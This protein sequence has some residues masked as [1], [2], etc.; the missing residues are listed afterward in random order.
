MPGVQPS[1]DSTRQF[2]PST[3]PPTTA[4]MS[5]TDSAL[6]SPPA[7]DDEMPVEMPVAKPAKPQPQSKA[8]KAKKNGTILSFLEKRA[9]SP[10]RKKREPSPPHEP[11][12]EDNFDIAVS[13][14][15]VRRVMPRCDRVL[16]FIH[17]RNCSPLTYLP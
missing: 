6:S 11:A 17:A 4:N 16:W 15:R 14:C 9:P 10:P 2:L 7:T 1:I 12:F 5:D 13:L 3:T 8:K